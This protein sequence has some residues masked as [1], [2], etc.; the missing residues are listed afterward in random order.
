MTTREMSAIVREDVCLSPPW[1]RWFDRGPASTVSLA[2][3]MMLVLFVLGGCGAAGMSP[4]G[5]QLLSIAV[6]PDTGDAVAPDGTIPFSATGNF[7][8]APTS[9]TNLAVA[10]SSSDPRI[11]TVDAKIG[12]ATCVSEGSPVTITASA[13][14]KEGVGTL[15][16]SFSSPGLTG[17][18]VYV[19]G[20]TRCGQ[21]T[22]Y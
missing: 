19:C 16:C 17:H 11:A 14:G 7:D 12:I 13:N 4:Q 8:Q 22:G 20:S 15:T 3:V 9:E 10:W 6:Q 21:L 5:R 18:C 1:S 2:I